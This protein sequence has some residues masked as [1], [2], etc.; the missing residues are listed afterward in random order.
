[1][2]SPVDSKLLL[3]GM[4]LG[5]ED[6]LLSGVEVKLFEDADCGTDIINLEGQE[7]VQIVV[8]KTFSSSVG[9]AKGHCYFLTTEMIFF[10][11]F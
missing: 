6:L 9:H 3:L 4:L 8:K 1:M 10:A 11:F 5:T 7:I 2:E